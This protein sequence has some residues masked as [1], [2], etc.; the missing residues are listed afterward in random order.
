M[1]G[2]LLFINLPI[3]ASAQNVRVSQNP[4]PAVQLSP[5]LGGVLSLGL[6]RIDA[7]LAPT[8]PQTQMALPKPVLPSVSVTPVG[9]VQAAVAPVAVSPVA[10]P[11]ALKPVAQHTRPT[12]FQGTRHSAASAA[13][14]QGRQQ[15]AAQAKPVSQQQVLQQAN[16]QILEA[17]EDGKLERLNTVFD[18]PQGRGNAPAV[19]AESA[20]QDAA[21][22]RAL[23]EGLHRTTGEGLVARDYHEAMDFLFSV[24]DSVMVKG[25]RGVIA[26][27]SGV[28]VAG[29]S[30]EG[31]RYRESHDQDGDGFV[32]RAGMNV[33]HLWP[34][35][36]F[37]HKLP[38]RSDMHHLMATFNH[39]NSE[40]SNHPFGE[41]A[42]RDAEYK[43]K[44]GAKLGHG[45]FEPPDAVKG[46][47]ARGMLY[48]FM[49]Y[50]DRPVLP[51]SVRDLFWNDKIEMFMR[52]NREHPPDA[53]ELRRNDLVEKWQGNRNPF[54][55]DP[56]LADKIGAEGFRM[57]GGRK[58]G[59][60]SAASRGAQSQG[61][62]PAMQPSRS[63]SWKHNKRHKHRRWR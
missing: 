39:S 54:V 13:Q 12:S 31:G 7:Q 46:R 56:A 27:Y 5:A 44:A 20:K 37:G 4:V 35:S 30:T 19:A 3:L 36:F 11:Q 48:F 53:F 49:R 40:R 34:Q 22:G 14:T 10:A 26:A 51:N 60:Q 33:E 52:W 21:S 32:D 42:D 50:Y 45:V 24:A 61:R 25:V 41:V 23:L 28:F 62:S 2:A 57:E 6:P 63:S 29:D 47:V 58:N 38:M 17:N 8:L 55:D 1:L 18:G 15:P 16:E 43:T 59:I 9:T